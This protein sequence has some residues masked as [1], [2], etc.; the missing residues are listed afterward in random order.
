MIEKINNWPYQSFWLNKVTIV[1]CQED[2][3]NGPTKKNA[4]SKHNQVGLA[5]SFINVS[6]LI[7]LTIDI[8]VT[9]VAQIAN[10]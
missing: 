7:V 4:N 1:T 8:Q 5:V 6:H 10:K 9:N 2:Y 3:V